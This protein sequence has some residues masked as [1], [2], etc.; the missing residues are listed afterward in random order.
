MFKLRTTWDGVFPEECLNQLDIGVNQIDR[1]WPIKSAMAMAAVGAPAVT[2]SSSAIE[3]SK[4]TLLKKQKELLE[5]Q[6]KRLELELLQT[7]AKLEEQERQKEKLQI[8]QD[9]KKRFPLF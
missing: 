3:A 5:L 7:K 9:V 1:A 8:Q 2:L 4:E 6:K